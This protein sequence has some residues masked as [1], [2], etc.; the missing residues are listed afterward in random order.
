MGKVDTKSGPE[1]ELIPQYRE[2]VVSKPPSV[3]SMYRFANIKGRLV[4]YMTKIGKDWFAKEL[5]NVQSEVYP[6]IDV[7]VMV[8]LTLFTTRMDQDL[9]NM[10]K[11]SM[12][13]L[14]KGGVLINDNQIV[15]IVAEKKKVPKRVDEHMEIF[16]HVVK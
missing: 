13:L 6:P 14:Q 1:L 5:P 4:S 10:F 15:R 7:P 12:D 11:A 8:G 16:V 3:N 2:F 9:D